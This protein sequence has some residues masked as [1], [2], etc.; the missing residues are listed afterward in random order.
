MSTTTHQVDSPSSPTRLAVLGTG[1][2]GETVLAGALRAG[3]QPADVVATVRRAERAQELEGRHGVTTTTD[4]TAAVREAGL[5]V[6]AVKP[7]DVAALLAEV[8]PHL[9]EGTVVVSVVVG[10]S[11]RFY[12][13][14]LPAGTA[15]VRVMPNTPSVIG[16]GVSAVSGGAAAGDDDVTLVER[17][18][19]R[20]GLVVRVAEKDQNAV[21]AL[22]GSGPAYVFYVVDA[23]A[24]AGVLL[25]LT[26]AVALEL[27]TATVLGSARMLDETGEH[28]VILRERVSSPGGTT[29]AALRALDDGGVRAAFLT[30]LEAARDRSEELAA[31]LEAQA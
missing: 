10:L 6:V 30:A 28:P 23:L 2:M 22:S 21:A 29:V 24:E 7:K 11:T 20:T 31:A 18:L 17:L 12:E 15:V 5:V 3:W 27:A 1:V 9:G 26:R 14:R 16:S 8:S 19:S 13:D 25:G 4:N